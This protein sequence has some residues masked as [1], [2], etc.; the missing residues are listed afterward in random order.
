MRAQLSISAAVLVLVIVALAGVL[1]ALRMDA[2]DRAEVDRQLADR[3]DRVEVDV[4]KLLAGDE[5]D[6]PPA[7]DGTDGYGGLLAGSDSLTRVLDGAEVLVQRGQLPAAPVPAPAPAADGYS[8]VEIDGA[9][10]RSLVTTTADG[11]LRLQ[12]LQSLAP[13]ED[14]RTANTWL[15]AGVTVAA[16]AL[17]AAGGWL[18]ARL[19][20]HPLDRLRRGLQ[21]VRADRDV[22][23]RLPTVVRPQ[24][25][26]ELSAT[27]NDMLERLQR[28][29]FAT[30]RFTADAGHELRT[31]L[32]SLGSYL[33]TLRRYPS[34]PP[35]QRRQLL[36]AAA[37]E[38]RRV[39][40]LLDGLQT[41][42][43][44]DAAIPGG[45]PV[46][47]A[48]LAADAV[49]RAARRHPGGT[50]RLRADAPADATVIG[51]PDGLR[52]ALDN[53]IDNAAKHG[54]PGGTVVVSV[55]VDG[56]RLALAVED[57]GPGL[58]AEHRDAVRQRFARGPHPRVDGSGLGLALVEQQAGLSGGALLLGD[59]PAGGLA[60]TLLLPRAGS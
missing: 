46:D 24:E 13:V 16:T 17:A 47:L 29:M 51:W 19:V 42:A 44:G 56:D 4:T 3:L 1:V 48:D 15:V 59:G 58:P 20:L 41:L 21:T 27:L 53:L 6:E 49:S 50:V 60:A 55:S 40:S 7:P 11:E 2:R 25:V 37:A 35:E 38:H 9:P 57:D 18:V 52:L 10:W 30:R 34:V 26:S 8:T 31:P 36:E 22:S 32:A 5:H 23:H 39:V 33:E 54:R 43:R 14:R 28:G 45:E 12:V